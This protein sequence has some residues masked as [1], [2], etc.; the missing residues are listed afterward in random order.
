M[1]TDR[2]AEVIAFLA[3]P[4]AYTPHPSEVERHETHGAIVFLAGSHAYKIKRAVRFSYMDFSTLDLR[5][6][7][8]LREVEI[9]R[10][11]APDLYLGVVA[12]TRERDGSLEIGG[13]GMPVEWAVQMRRFEQSALLSAMA[14]R[15]TL[16]PQIASRLAEAVRRAHEQAPVVQRADADVRI[17]DA[18]RKI[19]DE[20]ARAAPGEFASATRRAFSNAGPRRSIAPET[21]CGA[22]P[23]AA[24]C[25]TATAICI[26]TIS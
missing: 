18:M 4:A 26:S 6:K 13:G 17:G 2:Q 15:H 24:S 19:T 16:T 7:A 9:N 23:P 11:F 8:V 20:I 22:G 14:A 25:G 21:A 10:R 12:I 1:P 5:H 3:S